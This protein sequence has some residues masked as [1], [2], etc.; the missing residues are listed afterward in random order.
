MMFPSRDSSAEHPRLWATKKNQQ[1]APSMSMAKSGAH[2][3]CFSLFCPFFFCQRYR[4]SSP[5]CSWHAG[6]AKRWLAF[7]CPASGSPAQL[8]KFCRAPGASGPHGGSPPCMLRQEINGK[9]FCRAKE[10]Q[11]LLFSLGLGGPSIGGADAH[12]PGRASGSCSLCQ[13]WQRERSLLRKPSCR[14]KGCVSGLVEEEPVHEAEARRGCPSLG[15]APWGSSLC[16]VAWW[17]FSFLS[18]LLFPLILHLFYSVSNE[19]NHGKSEKTRVSQTSE[20]Y[21]SHIPFASL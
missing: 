14:A 3:V 10:L 19:K 9:E 13:G 6:P 8:A 4:I 17:G 15:C 7:G 2:G 16:R 1:L 12:R 5:V 20:H 18:L 11:Y 21:Q